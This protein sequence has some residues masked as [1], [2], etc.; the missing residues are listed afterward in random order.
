[1][2]ARFSAAKA[3]SHPWISQDGVAP[4]TPLDIRIMQNIQRFAG[5]NQVKKAI[6]V[7]VAK[8]FE[9]KELE[10]LKQQFALLDKDDSG[11]I[12][13]EEMI[14]ALANFRTGHDGTAVYHDKD[15]RE[16]RRR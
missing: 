11:T 12:S 3:L 2:Q 16:V 9:P 13:I 1:M 6:L 5:Y 10:H 8:T 4:D 14:Q 7:E 15:V